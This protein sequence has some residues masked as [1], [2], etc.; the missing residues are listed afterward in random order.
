MQS[1][2]DFGAQAQHTFEQLVPGANAVALGLVRCV[3]EG[4]GEPQL[5]LFGA[6][7]C[8]KTHLLQAACQRMGTHGLPAAYLSLAEALHPGV[9]DGLEQLGLVA[10]D[11]I[12]AVMGQDMWELALFDLINRLREQQVP[13][14]LAADAPPSML[15]VNLPDLAS[16]LAWGPVLRLE[17]LDDAGKR[18]VLRAHAEARGME[19]PDD[20]IYFMFA[21][22]P[23][24]LPSLLAGLEQLDAASMVQKRRVTL[25]LAREV[26]ISRF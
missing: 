12:Q 4:V 18:E 19:L 24:G 9:L 1:V 13:L 16:R 5:Y 11:D 14:L 8:G 23:R 10:L 2:F 26:F 3:T 6:S 25:S 22:L 21:H 7:G 20:V 15:A 17:V